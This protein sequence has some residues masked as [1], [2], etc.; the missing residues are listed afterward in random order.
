[1]ISAY[2]PHPKNVARQIQQRHARNPEA[3]KVTELRFTKKINHTFNFINALNDLASPNAAEAISCLTG[4]LN[5]LA[6]WCSLRRFVLRMR[7]AN[8]S[9]ASLPFGSDGSTSSATA[10]MEEPM[11][12]TCERLS[13]RAELFVEFGLLVVRISARSC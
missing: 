9:C 1:M 4:L 11:A 8:S 5:S 3:T 6:L 12:I 2:F 13:L 10:T 7:S